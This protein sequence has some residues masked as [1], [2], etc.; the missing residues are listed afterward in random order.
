MQFNVLMEQHVAVAIATMPSTYFIR[1]P[2][3][4]DVSV[5][6]YENSCQCAI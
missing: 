1:Y 5:H 4:W 3:V 6:L 2:Q